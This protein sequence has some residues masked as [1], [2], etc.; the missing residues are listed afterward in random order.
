MLNVTFAGNIFDSIETQYMDDEV[1]YQ[2]VHISNGISTWNDVH[3]SE[4]GQYNINLGDGDWLTQSGIQNIDDKVIICFWINKTSTRNDLD[5]TEWSYI[6]ID[7][8]GSSIYVNDAQTMP[9]QS[10]QCNFT[11]FDNIILDNVGTTN[12]QF[13]IFHNVEQFQ[14]YER[15][16][17]IIFPIMSFEPN[18]VEINW[19]DGNIE[20]VSLESDYHHEYVLAGDYHII[21]KV[22]N[23]GN[24]YCQSEFDVQAV[25]TIVPG[26][27]WPIPVFR[28][29]SVT[30]TPNIT[31]DV[32]QITDVSYNINGVET[33]AGLQYSESF[34]HT[35]NFPGPFTIRQKITYDNIF[36]TTVIYQDY[37]VYI[38][39]IA[40]FYK[41]AGTCGPDFIDNSIVG[42]GSIQ[43]Y[44]WAV[45]FNDEIIAEYTG[46]SSW[47]YTWPYIGIFTVIHKI[48]DS[49]GHQFGI[50]R[51]YEVTECSGQIQPDSGGGGGGGWT[52]TVYVEREFPKLSVEKLIDVNE[53]INIDMKLTLI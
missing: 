30:F 42:N 41:D 8:D 46:D 45:K 20:T 43:E 29:Y 50:E 51:T 36:E 9:H 1:A 18:S 28:E 11:T 33:Y 5:L 38:D 35:F 49:E 16:N 31:G 53:H 23:R 6:E 22:T 44:Y 32:E 4:F 12:D 14:R 52:Q 3:I 37:I 34:S 48:K 47:E 40:N 21:V 17:N 13:W 27:T 15:L 26:L 10:P 39:S 2:A 25:F 19:G 24:L 7:L